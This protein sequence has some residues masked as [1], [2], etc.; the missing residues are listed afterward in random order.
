MTQV[1]AMF[2]PSPISSAT[3]P[4][5]SSVCRQEPGPTNT[6]RPIAMR[7]WFSRRTGGSST[8]PFP[9][10]AKP[11]AASSENDRRQARRH[12]PHERQEAAPDEASRSAHGT[13]IGTARGPVRS[14][15]VGDPASGLAIGLAARAHVLAHR[16]SESKPWITSVQAM[17]RG[18]GPMTRTRLAYALV[19]PARNEAE[20]LRALAPCVAAQTVLPAGV[21]DR[22][23]R[24]ERRHR[25]LRRRARRR[26]SVDP[27]SS[28]ARR[29]PRPCAAGRSSARSR[30]ASPHLRRAPTSS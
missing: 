7:P 2:V 9:N 13:M 19:T 14:P 6:S 28:G 29:I 25:R 3:S 30:P 26:P 24:L 22:R 15:F 17:S 16:G 5:G 11:P 23:E 20:N 4:R 8:L 12:E 27:A 10:S 1:P 18:P 21:G